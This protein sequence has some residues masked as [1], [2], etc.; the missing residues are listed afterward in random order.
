MIYLKILGKLYAAA[1]LTL[2]LL[3]LLILVL[4]LALQI[5]YTNSNDFPSIIEHSGTFFSIIIIFGTLFITPFLLL[6]VLPVCLILIKKNIYSLKAWLLTALCVSAIPC[7]SLLIFDHPNNL[8]E[9]A[10]WT[11]AFMACGLTTAYL[12]WRW[13]IKP[14]IINESINNG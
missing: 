10:G 2:L 12:F 4:E 6:L 11:S 7:L 5:P 9:Y 14:R 1:L 13:D 8:I 3:G